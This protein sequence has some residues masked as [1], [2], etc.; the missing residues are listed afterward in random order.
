MKEEQI[1]YEDVFTLKNFRMLIVVFTIAAALITVFNNLDIDSYIKDFIM[2]FLILISAFIILL[3]KLNLVKNRKA[4]LYL[5]PILLSLLSYLF[6]KIDETNMFLN[7]FF[8]AIMLSKFVLALVNKKY[9]LSRYFV[10]DFLN[11]FPVGLFTNLKYL[12]LAKKKKNTEKNKNAFNIFL[13]CVIGIPIAIIL[14]I[15]LTDADIYFKQFIETVFTFMKKIIDIE[16]VIPNTIMIIISFIV[17]FSTFINIL[18]RRNDETKEIKKREINTSIANTVLIIVNSVFVLFL[19]SELSKFTVNFL[20]LPEEYTYSSY[21]REGFFQLLV[22]TII[23]VSIILY[24]VYC[25]TAIKENKLI[26]RLLTILAI[27]SILLIL[28]SYY[29]VV[30]YV[31]A[32]TFTILRAQVILFLIMELIILFHLEK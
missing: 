24:F 6:I 13:G 16:Y 12:Q 9:S 21:A 3:E 2:P 5:I 15:L 22:V 26:K 8:V 23:N 32:Y 29:R 20:H 1:K 28:S 27:F 14:L 31:C 19:V 11:L 4:Y 25:T 10:V 17:L 18:R 30:L 7:V